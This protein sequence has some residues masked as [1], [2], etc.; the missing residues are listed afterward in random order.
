VLFYRGWGKYTEIRFDSGN[1]LATS[2]AKEE[3]P[4]R[5][6]HLA[7]PEG[8]DEDLYGH[9]CSELDWLTNDELDNLL[10]GEVEKEVTEYGLAE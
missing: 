5:H 8:L 4:M 6:G 9:Y 2:E 3:N 7:L 1:F 10:Y